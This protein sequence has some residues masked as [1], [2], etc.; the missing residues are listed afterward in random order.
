[1]NRLRWLIGSFDNDARGASAKKLT[2][3]LL[4]L[5]VTFLHFTYCN[6]SN[7][8]EFLLIDCTTILGLLGV[9]SWEKLKQNEQGKT[10]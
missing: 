9:S 10:D 2:S 5:L 4:S 6:E 7:A 3:F 1:M 8:V